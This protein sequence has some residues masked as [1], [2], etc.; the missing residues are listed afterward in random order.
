MYFD[1]VGQFFPDPQAAVWRHAQIW[2]LKIGILKLLKT[3]IAGL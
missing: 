1:P 2:A 3:M